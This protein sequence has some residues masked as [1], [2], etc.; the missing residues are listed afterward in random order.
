MERSV[1]PSRHS[2][3]L[4]LASVREVGIVAVIIVLMAIVGVRNP[5]F[6]TVSNFVDIFLDISIVSIVVIGQM[7]VIITRGI[8]LS[9]SSN[10]GLTAMV[11]GLLIRDNTWLNPWLTIPIGLAIGLVLGLFNGVLVTKGRVPPIITTLAT[12]SIYRGLAI[13]ISGGEWVD[14]YRIPPGFADITRFPI[15][16]VP[17]LIIYAALFAIGF[18]YFLNYTRTG[19][20]IYAVGSNPT[21]AMLSGIRVDRIL[22]LVFIVSGLLA[23]LAGVLWASR[24]AVVTND[25]GTGFELQTVAAAV[26]GGVN[27]LGGSG[28]VPGVLLGSLLLGI[29]VNALTI[30]GISPFWRL[31]VQGFIILFAVVVDALIVRRL[32]VATRVRRAA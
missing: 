27:I 12:L 17:A 2:R 4:L 15:F 1:A 7:M 25:T 5:R 24:Y 10:L 16:G 28:T 19:R 6:M 26:I 30:T 29:I 8:D 22:F 32:Q 14:A 23:G 31:T 18:Y 20:Q 11:V 13:V 9:V 21:A 3:L